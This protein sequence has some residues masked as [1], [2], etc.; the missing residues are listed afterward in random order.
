MYECALALKAKGAVRVSAFVTHA[1]FPNNCW[2]D[3]CGN[4]PK[5]IFHKFFVTNSIPTVTFNLPED[6]V[7]EVID[8]LPQIITDLDLGCADRR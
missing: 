7:F 5:A 6:D 4:G 8:L 3:F 1:V 2:R